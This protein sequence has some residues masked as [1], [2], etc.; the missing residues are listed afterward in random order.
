VRNT[1]RLDRFQR[2]VPGFCSREKLNLRGNQLTFSFGGVVQLAWV[3]SMALERAKGL[4]KSHF[5]NNNIHGTF[6]TELLAPLQNFDPMEDY[7]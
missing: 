7:S 5:T 2:F 6:P 4:A 1:H 3:A